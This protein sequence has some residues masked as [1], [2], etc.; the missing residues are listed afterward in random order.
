MKRLCTLLVLT[1]AFLGSA[2]V[3]YAGPTGLPAADCAPSRL[4]FVGDESAP[5]TEFIDADGRPA[6]I[7]VDLIRALERELGIPIEIRLMPR[8]EATAAVQEG[9][10]HLTTIALA[11][12]RES[13]FDFLAQTVRSR[14]SVL[15]RKGVREVKGPTDLAGLR[16][17]TTFNSYTY[18]LLRKMPVHQRPE[19]VVVSD[20]EYAS[21]I[22]A[23]GGVDGMAGSGAALTWLARQQGQSNF[24]EIPFETVMMHFVTRRGCGSAFT[25]VTA[26]MQ[27]LRDRGIVDTTRERWLSPPAQNW[28]PAF[29]WVALFFA[30]LVA[31]MAWNWMLR[32]QVR[33]RTADLEKAKSAAEAATRAKS[34]F[35]ATMSHE[36]RT[37]LNAVI[38]TAS[39]LETTVLDAEQRELVEVIRQG[40][41][42]LLSVV[43]DVLDFSKVEAGK[44]E[45]HVQPFDVHA[46]VHETVALVERTASDKGLTVTAAIDPAVP[47]WLAGDSLRLRQV[48]LNLL[49]NAVKFTSAGMVTARVSAG[50]DGDRALLRV[51][52]TD[53]GPGIAA[54]RLSRL[55]NPFTQADSSVTRRFGGTGLGLT[56]SRSLIHVMGGDIT[57]ESAVGVGS[58]FS[59]EIP[60]AIAAK[61]PDVYRP[62]VTGPAATLNVLM[63]E[64]NPINQLVQRRMITQLGH[65]CRVVND[66]AEAIAAAGEDQYDVV[67]LD[68]QMPHVGGL[69]AA[70]GIRLL[71]HQPWLIIL[72]ADA[73]AD[74]REE[75]SRADID[76]FLTKPVTLEGMAAA[77]N[78]VRAA[79]VAA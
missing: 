59:F 6:G 61:P 60:L 26:A 66:G 75:C 44:L 64:D 14:V 10:A 72:T 29:R 21:R 8:G 63:A 30:V 15:L 58:T 28:W 42:S 71:D 43:S 24:V 13:Q 49:S 52:V 36:I 1:S 5:P 54:D 22:W 31:A 67:V 17:T 73:T 50:R 3:S 51:A 32:R 38:A 77:L 57:V 78:R 23:E 65:S 19:L 40:G 9:R 37:P 20:K 35:L 69:D 76:D 56:I 34:E 79:R 53:S 25:A 47:V 18:E 39:I 70:K 2:R 48:I 12:S 46:L 62:A 41:K 33:E 45:L 11:G 74:T 7:H 27:S 4:V 68:L 55:F 16:V